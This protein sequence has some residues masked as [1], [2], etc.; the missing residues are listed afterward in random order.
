MTSKAYCFIVSVLLFFTLFVVLIDV[1]SNTVNYDLL[2]LQ[3]KV[4]DISLTVD[5]IYEEQKRRT[6]AIEKINSES[7]NKINV[8]SPVCLM[9]VNNSG[10]IVSCSEGIENLLGYSKQEALLLNA[11]SFMTEDVKQM[12]IEKNLIEDETKGFHVRN[13]S[14]NC[15]TKNGELIALDI[16]ITKYIENNN[17]KFLILLKEAGND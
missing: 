3:K 9:I 5:I 2:I 12:H 1:K 16:S 7:L 6:S 11:Y 15:V 17:V 14:G 4:K 13:L 10:N 8:L